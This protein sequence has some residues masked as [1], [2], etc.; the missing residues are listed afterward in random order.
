MLRKD[1]DNRQDICQKSSILRISIDFI[2]L[3]MKIKR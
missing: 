1:K 3:L 2:T